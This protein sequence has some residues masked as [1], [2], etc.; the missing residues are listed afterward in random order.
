[1]YCDHLRL[2]VLFVCVLNRR[3]HFTIQICTIMCSNLQSIRLVLYNYRLRSIKF[4]KEYISFPNHCFS[5]ASIG[6]YC[7]LHVNQYNLIDRFL[8]ILD[9]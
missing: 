2:I 8:N 3:P 7:S 9:N 6:L 5:G 4:K 1:M